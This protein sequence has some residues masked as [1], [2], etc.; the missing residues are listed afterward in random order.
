[1]PENHDLIQHVSGP[2]VKFGAADRPELAT[3][4]AARRR[5]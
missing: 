2:P 5:G 4:R 1:M 3:T